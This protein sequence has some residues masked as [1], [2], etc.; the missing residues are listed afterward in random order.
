MELYLTRYSKNID[1]IHDSFYEVSNTS[2]IGF[3]SDSRGRLATESQCM[4]SNLLM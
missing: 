2:Y 1:F 4:A 3:V